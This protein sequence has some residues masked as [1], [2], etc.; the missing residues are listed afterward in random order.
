MKNIDVIIPIYNE[1]NRIIRTC[2]AVISF[3]KENKNFYFTFLNDGSSDGTLKRIE[4][5][6]DENGSAQIQVI[7][8]DH[9]KG[10]GAAVRTGFLKSEH[11]YVCFLDGDLAYSLDHLHTLAKKLE[12][13]D[14]VIGS[15][16]LGS[17]NKKN[18]PFLRRILGWGF[19]RLMRII[20]GLPFRDTQAGLKGFSFDAAKTVSKRQLITGFSFDA[21]IIFI[22]KKHKYTIGEVAA[23]VADDHSE[24]NSKVNLIKDSI[25]MFISLIRIR[26]YD[27]S[28]KYN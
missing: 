21:E 28:G 24:K 4:Q 7:S 14:V 16:S 25:K 11:D 1:E 6:I 13:C 2:D 3:L 10:K 5:K 23:F 8:H 9:N 19:N 20:I 18:I 15:R 22:A 17:D 27:I 12:V 26:Y